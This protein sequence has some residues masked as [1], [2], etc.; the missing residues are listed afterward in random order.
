MGQA[1]EDGD[2]VPELPD[3]GDVYNYDE[4]YGDYRRQPVPEGED[5]FYAPVCVD[6]YK[7]YEN[8]ERR[9]AQG[10][11]DE[12]SEEEEEAETE[13]ATE[14][15]VEVESEME[16]S[17]SDDEEEEE[18][19]EDESEMDDSGDDDESADASEQD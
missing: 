5:G 10:S 19:E 15:E 13:E 16:D 11:E 6:Y 2:G 12:M 9:D 4:L 3:W 8:A 18:E 1:I 7:M 14:E 17:V